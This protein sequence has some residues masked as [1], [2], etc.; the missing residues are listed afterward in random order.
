MTT[1]TQ[2][3]A[4]DNESI[5]LTPSELAELIKGQVA[6]AVANA[7]PPQVDKLR[8]P[9][10][11]QAGARKRHVPVHMKQPIFHPGQKVVLTEDSEKNKGAQFVPAWEVADLNGDEEL[12]KRFNTNSPG[13]PIV[14]KVIDSKFKGRVGEIQDLPQMYTHDGVWKY[15]VVWPGAGSDRCLETELLPSS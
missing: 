2:P 1:E 5:T 13:Q 14:Y 10:D 6:E 3:S 4:V 7:L 8:R 12:I 9:G 11:T 15:D